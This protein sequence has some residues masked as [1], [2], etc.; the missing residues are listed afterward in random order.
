MCRV[1]ST[2]PTS[3]YLVGTLQFECLV[4]PTNTFALQGGHSDGQPNV[5]VA[6]QCLPCTHRSPIHRMSFAPCSGPCGCEYTHAVQVPL[7]ATA[8][9]GPLWRSQGIGAPTSLARTRRLPPCSSCPARRCVSRAPLPPD[10]AGAVV[11]FS[12]TRY[13]IA[14]PYCTVGASRVAEGT[15]CSSAAFERPHEITLADWLVMA[16]LL[17]QCQS[18]IQVAL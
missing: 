3:R 17:L 12:R 4:C 9:R 10:G 18:R 15:C 14:H 13:Y 7:A 16:G 2:T 5:A 8:S 6:V 11:A 1:W